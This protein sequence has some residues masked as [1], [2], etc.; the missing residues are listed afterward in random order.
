MRS[1]E[2]VYMWICKWK[3]FGHDKKSSCDIAANTALPCC[4]WWI[5]S[6]DEPPWCPHHR[7]RGRSSSCSGH[8]TGTARRWS[9]S[10]W[11][12]RDSLRGSSCLSSQSLARPS[13]R[14]HRV[15]GKLGCTLHSHDHSCG[16]RRVAGSGETGPGKSSVWSSWSYTGRSRGESPSLSPASRDSE[17]LSGVHT[18]DE[19]LSYSRGPLSWPPA[20]AGVITSWH[21]Q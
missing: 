11:G 10:H 20:R 18:R 9:H 21:V 16:Q 6:C 1:C 8:C 3:I 17:P 2:N 13:L 5:S 7:T 14:S 15:G 19:T 12:T 4:D